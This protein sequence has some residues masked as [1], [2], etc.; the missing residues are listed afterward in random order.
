[1]DHGRKKMFRDAYTAVM[2][3]G[4]NPLAALPKMVT[5]QLMTSLAWMWSIV[6][7]FWVGSLAVF[8]PSMAGHVVLLIG[9][10]FTVDVF[11]RARERRQ[12]TYDMLFAH[13]KDGC[14]RYDDVW[15][16]P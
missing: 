9:V 16:A 12:V 3:P 4:K 5:F 8:G 2:D 10:F 14:A 6:F 7:S 11:S 15:G 13:K 1:M